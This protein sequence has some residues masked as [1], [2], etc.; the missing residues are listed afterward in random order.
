MLAGKLDLGESEV[1]MKE[2]SRG[3]YSV[4]RSLSEN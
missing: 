1:R 2:D 4:F 3:K